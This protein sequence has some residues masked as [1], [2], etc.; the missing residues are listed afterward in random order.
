LEISIYD[1]V[2]QK[3][4]GG[5]LDGGGQHS[6]SLDGLFTLETALKDP[7]ADDHQRRVGAGK[8]QGIQDHLAAKIN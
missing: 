1:Q 4:L 2:D 8:H 6:D 7:V 3:L 5:G